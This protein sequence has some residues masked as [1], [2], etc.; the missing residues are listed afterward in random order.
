MKKR[1]AVDLHSSEGKLQETDRNIAEQIQLL[2][3]KFRNVEQTLAAMAAQL[4]EEKK[5]RFHL[6]SIVKKH[7]AAGNCKDIES[8]EWSPMENSTVG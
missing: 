8:I 7:L 6:Q 5:A 2:S 4:N 3:I 1:F